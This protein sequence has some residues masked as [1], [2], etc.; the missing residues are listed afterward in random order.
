MSSLIEE[1]SFDKGDE[2]ENESASTSVEKQGSDEKDGE[3]NVEKEKKKTEEK[4]ERGC[5]LT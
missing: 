2:H 3:R 4:R 5:S 1:N